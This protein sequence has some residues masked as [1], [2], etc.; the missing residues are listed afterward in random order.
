MQPLPLTSSLSYSLDCIFRRTSSISKSLDVSSTC[1]RVIATGGLSF[2]PIRNLTDSRETCLLRVLPRAQGL[3]I[4]IWCY[5]PKCSSPPRA[6]LLTSQDRR[7]PFLCQSLDYVAPIN[8]TGN[9][10]CG[11]YGNSQQSFVSFESVHQG[12]CH[13]QGFPPP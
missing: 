4:Q 5:F 9:I 10:H 13:P 1:S 2:C 3:L 11:Q 7:R 6:A 8:F 12:R